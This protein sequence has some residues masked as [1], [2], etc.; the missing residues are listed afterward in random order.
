MVMLCTGC[1]A[2]SRVTSSTSAST[3]TVSSPHERFVADF[4]SAYWKLKPTSAI[5]NGLF[6]HAATLDPYDQATRDRELAFFDERLLSLDT[7]DLKPLDPNQRSDIEL[8][9][10]QLSC[11]RWY[12]T[13]FKEWQ[14]NPA[15]YNVA[16]SFD[17]LVQTEYAPLDKRL[18]TVSARLTRVPAYYA[19]ARA[20]IDHPTLEH[21]ELAILQNKG[22]LETF[23]DD[24][25]EKVRASGLSGAEKAEFERRALAAR[26]AIEAYIA[27]LDGTLADLRSG[28]ARPF[29]IGAP[30]YEQK[31]RHDYETGFA[32]SELYERALK[33]KTWLHDQ[34]AVRAADLWP[35]YFPKEAPPADRLEMIHRLLDKLSLDHVKRD[36]LVSAIRQQIP[37]LEA[38]VRERDLVDQDPTHPLKVRETPAYQRGDAGASVSA[39]GPY[40]PGAD[41]FY[42]VTP[43]DHETPEEAESYLR[44]YNRWVLQILNIHEAIPGHY[45]QLVHANRSSSIVKSVFGDGATIEGWAVYGERMMLTAGYGNNEPEM[46]LFWMKWNLRSVCNTILDY[47]VHTQGMTREQM[48]DLVVREAFQQDVEAVQ[49][50]R[51]ATLT[52]VQLTSYYAGYASIWQFRE[53]E[54]QRLGK[55]FDLKAFHNRFLS[56]G[57]AP[58]PV[59]KA[60]MRE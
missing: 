21:T 29:R 40:N 57:S 30:T 14:W 8:I 46:W 9:R 32:A 31:F 49:K 54:Q 7:L 28:T 23:N 44:E 26:Q 50:W 34:M 42:N 15:A 55:A 51:R 52:S 53:E 25:L 43:L 59:I 41:T 19:A 12:L 20:N 13:S 56:Y 33:E 17:L 18:R 5:S 60:L 38:F 22:G 58:V 10:H 45:T 2:T 4:M 6:D 35:K 16:E 3:A 48:M 36:E 47:A 37:Q 27:F 24:L 1:A 39:P 11:E